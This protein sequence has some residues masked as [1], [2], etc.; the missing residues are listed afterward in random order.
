MFGGKIICGSC[1]WSLHGGW[2][3]VA[4]SGLL[5]FCRPEPCSLSGAGW[6]G[7]HCFG[8]HVG[9]HVTSPKRRSGSRG[10]RSRGRG[11]EWPP[12]TGLGAGWAGPPPL[13]CPALL[14]VQMTES[15]CSKDINERGNVALDPE[16]KT[17]QPAP[18]QKRGFFH[19]LFT[20]GVR[21][22]H[23]L[24]LLLSHYNGMC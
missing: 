16:E 23:V 10:S 15:E 2:T 11:P 21:A 18:R 24:L 12:S 8:G 7:V 20:R 6:T 4:L 3:E 13:L 5:G 22:T 1:P 19:R 9:G 14:G 17:Y